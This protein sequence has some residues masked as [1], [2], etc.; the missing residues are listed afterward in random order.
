[1]NVKRGANILD[2]PCGTGRLALQ[3]AKKGFNVTGVDISEGF[4]TGLTEKVKEDSLSIEVIRENILSLELTGSLDG[5]YC[6]GNS[7]G[8]FDYE[9]MSVF[10]K[11]VAACLK[12]RS[13]YSD[14][15]FSINFS[16]WLRAMGKCSLLSIMSMLSLRLNCFT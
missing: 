3:L 12:P 14:P 1:M 5:A 6:A 11:K 10:V 9:G 13:Y 2:I 16:F 4:I 8:Y 15:Y 7:F